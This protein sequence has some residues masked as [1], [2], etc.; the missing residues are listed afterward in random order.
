MCTTVKYDN[1]K[2]WNEKGN[3]LNQERWVKFVY[4][5]RFIMIVAESNYGDIMNIK[6][7]GLNIDHCSLWL[8]IRNAGF[9]A[10]TRRDSWKYISD[11][12]EFGVR[13]FLNLL[14]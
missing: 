9:K 4:N 10:K 1:Y 6:E 7:I 11:W 2:Q 14:K 5:N 12:K 3:K 13:Q 8:K